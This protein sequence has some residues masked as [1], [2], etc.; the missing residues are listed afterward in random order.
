[1]AFMPTGAATMSE[2]IYTVQD[3]A[4]RLR[5]SVYTIYRMIDEGKLPAFKVRASIRIY[6]SDVDAIM[7]RETGQRPIV[8]PEASHED[9]EDVAK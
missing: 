9:E 8:K 6:K 5:V 4:K 2:E 7:M 1:M 3:A